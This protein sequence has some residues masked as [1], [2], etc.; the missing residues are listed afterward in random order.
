MKKLITSTIIC[1]AFSNLC[2][3]AEEMRE[4]V[5]TGRCSPIST[6]STSDEQDLQIKSNS[7][8]TANDN[9][10][11]FLFRNLHQNLTSHIQYLY[12]SPITQDYVCQFAANIT[13]NLVWI[14]N[15]VFF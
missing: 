6:Q 14:R 3:A 12:S 2:F 4:D 11:Y 10:H 15:R 8:L 5:E 9:H 7:L 13:T 1:M